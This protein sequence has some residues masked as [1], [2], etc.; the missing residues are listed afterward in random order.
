VICA[1][2][3]FGFSV[4]GPPVGLWWVVRSPS[5]CGDAGRSHYRPAEARASPAPSPPMRSMPQVSHGSDPPR[6]AVL[7][8]RGGIGPKF[9]GLRG[10][11]LACRGA[12]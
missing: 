1:T 2:G 10:P 5:Y 12:N 8:A 4:T 9:G 6:A 7:P 3:L 11:T